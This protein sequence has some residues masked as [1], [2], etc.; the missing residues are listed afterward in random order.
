MANLKL[1]QYIKQNE[2]N[3]V[4]TELMMRRDKL[5]KFAHDQN[6]QMDKLDRK[7]IIVFFEHWK[8]PERPK[9][10]HDL[11][12]TFFTCCF[13]YAPLRKY[14]TSIAGS[15]PTPSMLSSCLAKIYSEDEFL[16]NQNWI[17]SRLNE[18]ATKIQQM[19]NFD[20]KSN[21]FKPRMISVILSGTQE[22]ENRLQNGID[23]F[24]QELDK[25]NNSTAEEIWKYVLEF[26]K[27]IHNV[28]SALIC[29]FLKD[30]GCDR[31]VKV[32]HH[33]K[34]EFPYLLGLDN[35]K[36]LN[37]KEHFILSQ[38]ISNMLKMSPFHL[39]HLLY[40][41]GRYKKYDR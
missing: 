33:F 29:D 37:S 16:I 23:N 38:E 39:D 24:Y 30:I 3:A 18:I 21:K 27:R 10:I 5:I 2:I 14:L 31:F 9:D 6:L 17:P 7:C 13:T 15:I 32:D 22:M 25:I 20:L 8:I 12:K 36:R 19:K 26:P 4:H 28:G 41:W 34:K 1:S 40:Q 11:M 35:C